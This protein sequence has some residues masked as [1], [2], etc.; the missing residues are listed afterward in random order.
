MMTTMPPTKGTTIAG[1]AR[2]RKT[3]RRTCYTEL[4]GVRRGT[5]KRD[6]GDGGDRSVGW[7]IG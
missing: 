1:S 7:S 5:R 6:L 2:R 3:L 4:E